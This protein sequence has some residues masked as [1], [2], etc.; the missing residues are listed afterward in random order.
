MITF[1]LGHGVIGLILLVTAILV[2]YTG[3]TWPLH[4]AFKLN[5]PYQS[6]FTVKVDTALK[7]CFIHGFAPSTEVLSPV[8]TTICCVVSLTLKKVHIIATHY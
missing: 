6:R 2:V 4:L 7:N 8:A 1:F 5:G 3:S